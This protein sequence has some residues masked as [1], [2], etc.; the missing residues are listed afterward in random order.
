MSPPNTSIQMLSRVGSSIIKRSATRVAASR[1]SVAAKV[2]R[3]RTETQAATA[4]EATVK[5]LLFNESFHSATA[6]SNAPNGAG[7]LFLACC[8]RFYALCARAA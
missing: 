8:F 7:A 3:P 5:P 1:S 6:K 4:P 2:E